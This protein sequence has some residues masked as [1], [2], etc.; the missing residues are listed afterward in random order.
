M[1]TLSCPC[2]SPRHVNISCDSPLF[3]S[4]TLRDSLTVGYIKIYMYQAIVYHVYHPTVIKK[5][6]G[7]T[8]KTSRD[9]RGA[10]YNAKIPEISFETV[11]LGWSLTGGLTVLKIGYLAHS[12][13]PIPRSLF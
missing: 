2:P 11:S 10:Y 12:H 1:V 9:S 8:P 7:G 3:M 5:G 4:L 13:S 6:I